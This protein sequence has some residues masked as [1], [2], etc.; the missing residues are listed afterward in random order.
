MNACQTSTAHM[1]DTSLPPRTAP[2]PQRHHQQRP[3]VHLSHRQPPPL[4]VA[5]QHAAQHHQPDIVQRSLTQPQTQVEL[6]LAQHRGRCLTGPGQLEHSAAPVQQPPAVLSEAIAQPLQPRRLLAT[7]DVPS[8]V[9]IGD[10]AIS[11]T[12]LSRATETPTHAAT[13]T[14]PAPQ[15]SSEDPAPSVLA[16]QPRRSAADHP[17]GGP[18]RDSQS[19]AARPGTDTPP[20]QHAGMSRATGDLAEETAY[21]RRNVEHLRRRKKQLEEHC[22]YVEERLQSSERENLQYKDFYEQVQCTQLALSDCGGLEISMLH[23]QLNAVLLLKNALNAE[24]LELQ[25]KLEAERQRKDSSDASQ[26]A[27]CVVCMD[28]LANVVCLP[29]KH[30]ALCTFCSAQSIS[31]CPICRGSITEKMQIFMP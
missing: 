26:H 21:L 30:L 11:S 14:G 10:G 29:C 18:Q 25:Q 13:S 31:S 19:S 2:T 6:L 16:Q 22:R 5:H 15:A 20:A 28:N 7:F 8:F 9:G 4:P 1:S 23:Q 27:A 12:M 3:Q 17:S 24:N